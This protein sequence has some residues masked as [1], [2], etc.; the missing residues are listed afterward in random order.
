M[1]SAFRRV[2]LRTPRLE[3][4]EAA[5]ASLLTP[6]RLP[7]LHPLITRIDEEPV[8][9]EGTRRIADFLV[10]EGVPMLGGLVRWPNR[11]RGRVVLDTARPGEAR[12]SA[13][14]WPG[15]RIELRYQLID[16]SLEERSWVHAPWW[17][18]PFV[19]RTFVDSHRRTLE[20]VSR[21]RP[22]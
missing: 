1:P 12:L 19:F 21:S 11:Y 5:L 9:E 20:A 2:R 13:W 6:A 4:P 15:V 18:E 16:G 10:H 8:R 14:S 3:H 22:R 7:E 17:V